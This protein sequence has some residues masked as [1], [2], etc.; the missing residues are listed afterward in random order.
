VGDKRTRG[1]CSMRGRQDDV[2]VIVAVVRSSAQSLLFP[3]LSRLAEAESEYRT[4]CC[5]TTGTTQ[6]SLSLAMF[7]PSPPP[8][9]S[10]TTLVTITLATLTLFFAIVIAACPPPSSPLTLPLQPSLLLSSSS[11]SATRFR[12][13]SSRHPL[14]C[15]C[16]PPAFDTPIAS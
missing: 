13:S 14:S 8:S 15:S 2:T 12:C 3:T 6:S 1:R 10:P 9:S 16:P 11:A 5:T 7:P 4:A